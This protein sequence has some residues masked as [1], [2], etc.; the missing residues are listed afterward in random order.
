MLNQS[1]ARKSIANIFSIENQEAD[2]DDTIS[3]NVVEIYD[4]WKKNP[5]LKLEQS[6]LD[7]DRNQNINQRLK[8]LSRAI[9]NN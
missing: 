2:L 1:F 9:I 4:L 8:S 3:A 7:V 5:Q 6:H